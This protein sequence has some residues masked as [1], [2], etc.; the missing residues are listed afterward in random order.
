MIPTLQCFGNQQLSPKSRIKKK[1]SSE[2]VELQKK[3]PWQ[4]LVR[5]LNQKRPEKPNPYWLN[6]AD[7]REHCIEYI[8]TLHSKNY[9]KEERAEEKNKLFL[10]MLIES[11][12][13]AVAGKSGDSFY[14]DDVLPGQLRALNKETGMVLYSM[15]H[16]F[17]DV[18]KEIELFN[19]RKGLN[20]PFNS[21]NMKQTPPYLILKLDIPNLPKIN[22]KNAISSRDD[23]IN[24]RMNASLP[25]NRKKAHYYPDMEH[26]NI[27][28]SHMRDLFEKIVLNKNARSIMDQLKL[29]AEFYQ[30]SANIRPFEQVNNSLFMNIVNLLLRN[31]GLNGIPHGIL[32]HLAMRM[33]PENFHLYFI[34]KVLQFNKRNTPLVK[35]LSHLAYKYKK[36]EIPE[37]TIKQV[38]IL[39]R[40]PEQK[41]LQIIGKIEANYS[42]KDIINIFN[43]NLM[44]NDEIQIDYEQLITSNRD[45]IDEYIKL[46]TKADIAV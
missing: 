26:F 16:E 5:D 12:K 44:L 3:M 35:F 10:N 18:I 9:A 24:V 40:I 17:L 7:A 19:A 6:N 27:Y 8:K 25:I 21:S 32:D 42:L 33:Q 13:L 46:Y 34:D 39:L 38:A 23:F 4:D 43:I 20:D 2:L 15:Y 30:I 14:R 36:E 11:H 1:N 41:I 37:K 22:S 45:Y 29:I 31:S 28:V